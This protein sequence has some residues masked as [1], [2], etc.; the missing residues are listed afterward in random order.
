MQGNRI[1][2]AEASGTGLD[3]TGRVA[4]T[5]RI[6]DAGNTKRALFAVKKL[7]IRRTA[8]TGATMTPAIVQ[9]DEAPNT[10]IETAWQASTSTAVGVTLNEDFG[11]EGLYVMADASGKI[12]VVPGFD[13][14]ADNNCNV[15]LFLEAVHAPGMA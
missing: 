8:G 2:K 1:F 5:L 10:S 9:A 13:A 15:R 14:G 4:I 3:S 7:S 6:N 11:G 12:Y